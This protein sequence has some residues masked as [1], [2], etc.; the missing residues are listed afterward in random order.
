MLFPKI[1]SIYLLATICYR[2]LILSPEFLVITPLETSFTQ[3]T[4]KMQ[5]CEK[6]LVQGTTIKN[7]EEFWETSVDKTSDSA[8]I[9]LSLKLLQQEKGE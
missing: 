5:P 2:K 6:G 4:S 3:T 7:W 8:E 1:S 9:I